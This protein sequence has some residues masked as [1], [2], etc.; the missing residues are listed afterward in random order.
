M[1]RMEPL[2]WKYALAAVLFAGLGVYTRVP[3]AAPS[4]P[5]AFPHSLH[6]QAGVTCV[7]CH[8][9]AAGSPQAG[10]PSARECALCHAKIGTQSP[11][12]RQALAYEGKGEEIPWR[13]VY[14]F[15]A[16]AHVLF[17][18]DMHVRGG[19]ACSTCHG[20]MAGVSTARVWQPF[21]MGVCL[22]CH[23]EHAAGTECEQCHY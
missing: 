3:A 15:A 22:S 19:I 17:R 14:G 16:S 5:L 18:H 13:P 20:S 9:D 23:R 11:V 12:V 10:L 2:R 6:L 4:Q 1:R 21:S 8:R 7:G